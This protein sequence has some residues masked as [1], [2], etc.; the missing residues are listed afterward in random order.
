MDALV[1]QE[2]DF[3]VLKI[4]RRRPTSSFRAACSTRA[5]HRDAKQ[6]ARR[7]GRGPDLTGKVKNITSTACS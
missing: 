7:P 1:G 5:A 4:N 6:A 3:R 2:F